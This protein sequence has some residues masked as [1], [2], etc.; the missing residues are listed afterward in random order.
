MGGLMK[1]IPITFAVLACA[2]LAISGI[3][4]FARFYSKDEI[5]LAA[6]HHAPWMYWVGVIT[7][8]MTAFYVSRAMFLC[9]FGSYRGHHHPHE[10]PLVMWGP[11]AVLAGLSVGGGWYFKVTHYLEPMFPLNEGAHDEMLVYIS[12]GSG[13]AGIAIAYV[14]YVMSP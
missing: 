3:P 7:A 13:L 14:M 6:H 10:S 11:L 8:G 4:P 5:L 12:V 2:W 9:F 1:K